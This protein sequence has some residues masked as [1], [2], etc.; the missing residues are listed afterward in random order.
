MRGFKVGATSAVLVIAF[1]VAGCGSDDSSS[2]STITKSEFITQANE[3]CASSNKAIDTASEDAFSSNQPSDAE[4]ES[5]V[6]ET[7]IPEV[8]TQLTGIRDLG[9]P[10]GE[11]DQVNAILDAVDSAL[12]ESKVDP[13]SLVGESDPFAEANKL[14]EEYGL[15]ECAG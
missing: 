6:N 1:A 15:N 7:V 8:E 5:F 13:T 4:I 11:E 3:I 2:D 9:T 12:E 14:S 10:E